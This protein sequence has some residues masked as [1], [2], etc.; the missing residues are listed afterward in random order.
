MFS[1]FFFLD[2]ISTLSLLFDIGWITDL[3]FD[4]NSSDEAGTSS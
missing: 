4:T 2:I 1:F 3:I